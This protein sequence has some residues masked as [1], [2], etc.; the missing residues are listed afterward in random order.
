MIEGSFQLDEGDFQLVLEKLQH[1]YSLSSG[2]FP[3]LEAAAIRLEELQASL[4]WLSLTRQVGVSYSKTLGEVTL[5]DSP[6]PL[7]GTE[8]LAYIGRVTGWTTI[9]GH[10]DADVA[11]IRPE[12]KRLTKWETGR[13]SVVLGLTMDTFSEPLMEALS[14]KRLR[15][16]IQDHKLKLA[17][18]LFAAHRFE[19]GEN[20]QFITLVSALESLL[21]RK[22]ISKA[23]IHALD[24]AKAS[25]KEMR[26]ALN[27]PKS[28]E[29][30]EITHLLSRI[31][32]LKYESIGITLRNFVLSVISRQPELGDPGHISSKLKNAYSIRSKLL[33]DGHYDTQA[34]GESLSFLRQFVP[35]LLI[36]LFREAAD[37]IEAR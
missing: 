25:V 3:S 19:L 33:H 9:E 37:A 8:P 15:D 10:Y 2:P 1:L 16:V 6:K 4:L 18:E 14:F 34:I 30:N 31:G 24:R 5:Y 20:A 11:V 21:P 26:D 28:V 7:P 32:N 13:A 29:W 27:N 22:S 12:H 23:S 17:I 36:V 35:Q